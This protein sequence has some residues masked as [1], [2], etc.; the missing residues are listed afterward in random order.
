MDRVG[1]FHWVMDNTDP[2]DVFITADAH[3]DM[4]VVAQSARKLVVAIPQYS[5]PYV[6]WEDRNHHKESLFATLRG[7]D[8]ESFQ[9]LAQETSLDYLVLSGEQYDLPF[10]EEVYTMSE[11]VIYQVVLDD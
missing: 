2:D 6:A 9:T 1:A 8:Y 5:N 10:L 11:L 4:F 3:M 7:G